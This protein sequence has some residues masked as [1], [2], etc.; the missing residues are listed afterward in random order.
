VRRRARRCSRPPTPASTA[1]RWRRAPSPLTDTRFYGLDYG[2]PALCFGA[3][4]ESIHGFD[5]RVDLDSV[6]KLTKTLALFIAGWCG[7]EAA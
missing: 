4:A 1:T 7:V 2:I 3:R 5:E 6:K